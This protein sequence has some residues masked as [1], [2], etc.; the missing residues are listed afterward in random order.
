VALLSFVHQLQ[1]SHPFIADRCVQIRNWASSDE[2]RS[3]LRRPALSPLQ[4]EILEVDVRDIPATD[5]YVPMIDSGDTDPFVELSYNSRS[6]TSVHVTD[7]RQYRLSNVDARFNVVAGAGLI[8]DLYDYNAVLPNRLVA[9]GRLPVDHV[10]PGEYVVEGRLASDM[11]DLSRSAPQPLVRVK[12]R[13][14]A[15]AR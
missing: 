4:L 12:Y 11:V 5:T 6:L 7:S 2:Y 10:N 14:E 3:L 13:I 1:A 15:A 8:V 9:S